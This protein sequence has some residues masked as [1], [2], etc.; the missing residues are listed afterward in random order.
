[1][2][3]AAI[4]EISKFHYL[5]ELIK[6]KPNEDKLGLSHTIE[7]YEEAKKILTST[8]GKDIK[9][10]RALVKELESLHAVISTQKTASIHDF[11]K[12]LSRIVTTPK[13][14]KKLDTAQSMV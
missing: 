12:R 5:L 1:M 6:G 3:G 13:T 9:V 7:S 10:H 2:D 14:L 4:S 11:Y 8:Y